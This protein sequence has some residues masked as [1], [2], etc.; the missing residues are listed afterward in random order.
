[1]RTSEVNA[2]PIPLEVRLMLA[3]GLTELLAIVAGAV[4]IVQYLLS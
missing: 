1:M 3:I 2:H 4:V